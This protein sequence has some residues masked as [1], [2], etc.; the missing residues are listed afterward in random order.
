MGGRPLHL[1]YRL[2][3]VAQLGV[4]AD[5]DGE[6][7]IQ[8]SADGDHGVGVEAAVGPQR[9]WSGG[10]GVTHPPH[11]LA[12]E[13][14]GAPSRVGST[15]AQPC[16]QHVPSAS[17][18]SEERVIAPL[19]GVVVALRTLL[20]QPKGLADG[21]VQVNGQ[22]SVARTRPAAQAWASSSRLTRSN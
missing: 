12:Q 17:G 14:G 6:A 15:F 21:G 9:E 20:G 2:D 18:Y 11:R 16:H 1:G 3:D 22:R 7:D 4:L 10:S 13:V 8:L 19:A 5:G